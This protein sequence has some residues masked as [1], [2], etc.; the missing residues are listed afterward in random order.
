MIVFL[1]IFSLLLVGMALGWLYTRVEVRKV[2]RS[3]KHALKPMDPCLDIVNGKIIVRK[4][5]WP[6][7]AEEYLFFHNL[8]RDGGT[9]EI[10]YRA[11][12]DHLNHF[13]C[14]ITTRQKRDFIKTLK[15]IR[16]GQELIKKYGWDEN[17]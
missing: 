6:R 17:L 12:E 1:K 4:Q 5:E 11:L 14:H 8:E 15:Q 9:I 13:A 3:L 2:K 16:G 7:D 10:S